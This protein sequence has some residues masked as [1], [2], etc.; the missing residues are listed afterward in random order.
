MYALDYIGFGFLLA[1]FLFSRTFLP[2]HRMFSLDD[3]A[4]QYPHAEHERVPTAILYIYAIAIPFGVITAYLLI[5]R[6][7]AHKL[8]VS[9]LGLGITLVLTEFLTNIGKN[10][11]GRPRPDLLDRCDPA[12]NTPKTGLVNYSVCTETDQGMLQ[13]GWRSFPSG[14]SSFS[15]AGLGYLAL[16]LAGQLGALRT[17]ANLPSLL[18]CLLPLLAA[19]GVAISRL[20]DYRH[21]P[22]DVTAGSLLGITVA[23][24]CY[25]RYF[26]RLRSANCSEPFALATEHMLLKQRDEEMGAENARGVGEFEL[27]AD[28]DSENGEERE[29]MQVNGRVDG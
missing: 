22:Y 24:V 16:H 14:H 28:D 15:F 25:R 13:D 11:I 9:L 19:A 17:G 27:T 20:E 10:A 5:G 8:H 26:P 1:A 3:E 2:F 7:S 6:A 29:P 18:L 4:I 23:Y 21:D 12:S